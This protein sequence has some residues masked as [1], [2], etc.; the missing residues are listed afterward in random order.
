VNNNKKMEFNVAADRDDHQNF[1][2]LHDDLEN[3][4]SDV[5]DQFF[6][7]DG[8]SSPSTN[9]EGIQFGN[10]WYAY[11]GRINLYENGVNHPEVNN[12]P[13]QAPLLHPQPQQVE[14]PEPPNQNDEEE[15]E[16][17][18]L[19]MDFEPENSEIENENEMLN[20]HNDVINGNHMNDNQLQNNQA[21]ENFNNQASTS[22]HN[23]NHNG[24]NIISNLHSHHNNHTNMFDEPCSSK[25]TGAKPKVLKQPLIQK[26]SK[27]RQVT[28]GDNV[29]RITGHLASYDHHHH[30][31]T[32]C[33]SKEAGCSSSSTFF[34]KP[35]SFFKPHRSPVKS[36]HNSHKQQDLEKQNESFLFEIEPIRPRNSVT[37]YTSNC[38]EK[39]LM[40]ALVN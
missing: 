10:Q 8:F 33:D 11:R 26:S 15:E 14:H 19:E 21:L 13:L 28:E 31:E 25:N 35:S 27:Q 6:E 9:S 4:D 2:E 18:F 16:T 23:N 1:N 12:L 30:Q 7:E 39:I 40:D 5:D 22:S 34:E 29:F 37:I 24:S 3:N 32:F 38:D 36:C 17:D 20:G